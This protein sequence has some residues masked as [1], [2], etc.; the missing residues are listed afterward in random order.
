MNIR[1]VDRDIV[2]LS[3]DEFDFPV[4]DIALHGKGGITEAE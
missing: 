1:G 3:F 4:K 2:N